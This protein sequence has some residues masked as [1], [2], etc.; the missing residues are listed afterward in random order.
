MLYPVFCM[1]VFCLIIAVT[2][3]IR[4]WNRFGIEIHIKLLKICIT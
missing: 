3:D 2:V 1:Y 4:K